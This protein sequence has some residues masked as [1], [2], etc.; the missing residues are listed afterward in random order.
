[1]STLSQPSAARPERAALGRSRFARG[2]TLG[3]LAAVLFALLASLPSAGTPGWDESG[4]AFA[5]LRMHAAWRE[6][7]WRALGA[8]LVRSDFYTPLGRACF[9]PAFAL[10][11]TAW[12]VPRLVCVLAWTTTIALATRLARRLVDESAR[13]DA[14][15]WTAL[16]GASC[17]LGAT[18]AR[19]AFLEPLSACAGAALAWLYLRFEERPTSARAA[20]LGTCAAF[21]VLVKPTY[22]LI[23]VFACALAWTV[24]RLLAAWRRARAAPADAN[25]LE[26]GFRAPSR[27]ASWSA[28]AT[29]VLAAL[30]PFLWWFVWPWPGG[31]PLAAEHRA[32]FVEYLTKA[33][34]L[35]GLT[36]TDLVLVFAL[37]C[38]W[39][40]PVALLQLGGLALGLWR[41]RSHAW[42]VVCALAA[43]GLLAFVVYPYRIERFLIPCLFA[44]WCVGG[45]LCSLLLE[46]CAA[47]WRPPIAWL[48]ALALA[49]CSDLG[50]LS[51]WDALRG[52]PANASEREAV[53]AALRSFHRPYA[54]VLAP[55]CGAAE[56]QRALDLAAPRVDGS[57]PFGWIGGTCTE[58]PIALVRWRLLQERAHASDLDWSPESVDHLWSDPGWDEAAF[59]DW[60]ARFE[61]LVVLDPP[62]PKQRP[63]RRF[64]LRFVDWIRRDPAFECTAREHIERAGRGALV[65]SLYERRR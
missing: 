34:A 4:H 13:D 47:R 21:G 64:E 6:H 51:L 56:I 33:A 65:W 43:G 14:A 18:H 38:C 20:A 46:R 9:V 40:L 7:G 49:S 19:T 45:A 58:I 29:L 3:V 30:L 37:Q 36:R 57:R 15:L 16:F 12:W 32:L 11:G 44:L 22:G 31:A 42:C 5:A 25:E 55:A 24:P 59:R 39:S 8:E 52:L 62:D 53:L 27:P 54:H 26:R 48:A 17:T 60:A 1:M 41:L 10:F 61:Q 35:E 50:A 2:L 23:A 28:R 63:A